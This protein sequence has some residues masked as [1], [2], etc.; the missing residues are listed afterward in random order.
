MSRAAAGTPRAGRAPADVRAGGSSAGTGD[1][2]GGASTGGGGLGGGA[3]DGTSAGDE[4]VGAGLGGC[5][6]RGS[7]STA[8]TAATPR[9]ARSVSCAGERP[10]RGR[11]RIR[12]SRSSRTDGVRTP[13]SATRG[14]GWSRT[15]GCAAPAPPAAHGIPASS[16]SIA[17]SLSLTAVADAGRSPGD[18]ASNAATRDRSA[19]GTGKG[20]ATRGGAR[21]RASSSVDPGGKGGRPESS[22]KRRAPSAYRSSAGAAG[23]PARCCGLMLAREP[24]PRRTSPSSS[25]AATAAMPKSARCARPASSSRTFDALTSRCTTPRP[26]RYSS[27]SATSRPRRTTSAGGAPRR[28]PASPPR[29]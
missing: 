6:Q 5:A 29:M 7:H 9:P 25:P 13:P 2:A 23:S 11:D 27:A 12:P 15:G 28:L 3:S 24:P 21:V 19:S 26:C 1:A 8:S 18:L 4:A 10:V 17:P 14:G 20:E 22:S 16:D